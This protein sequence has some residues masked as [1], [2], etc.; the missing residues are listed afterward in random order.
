MR[1]V[2]RTG[3]DTA[4]VH[5]PNPPIFR[6]WLNG[7]KQVA[8][9]RRRFK[10]DRRTI[11]VSIINQDIDLIYVKRPVL[12]TQRRHKG[13]R[14]P[15]H[16]RRRGDKSAAVFNQGL[17]NVSKVVLDVSGGSE[18]S[19]SLLHTLFNQRSHMSPDRK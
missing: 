17:N 10:H 12:V 9:A 7:T 6:H 18:S 4:E 1:P 11:H 2:Q 3:P 5:P 14:M 16:R 8:V 15:F 13:P 19:S